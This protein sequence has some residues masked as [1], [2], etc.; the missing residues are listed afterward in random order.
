MQ[1]NKLKILLIC[2][3]GVETTLS[4]IQEKLNILWASMITKLTVDILRH[5][6]RFDLTV[7]KNGDEV[8]FILQFDGVSS[9]YFVEDAGEKRLYPIEPDEGDYT[10]ISTIHYYKLG[11]GQL[12]I[13]SKSETW[14]KQYNSSANFALELWNSLL[15]IEASSI[16]ING[17]RFNVNYPNTH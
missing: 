16:L 10:E 5:S 12:N 3:E 14:V 15:L 4:E 13:T 6:I 1:L 7:I 17:D 11:V 8:D 9:F 2:T